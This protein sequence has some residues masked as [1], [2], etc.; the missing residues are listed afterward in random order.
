VH[1]TSL[2]VHNEVFRQFAKDFIEF[3]LDTLGIHRFDLRFLEYLSDTISFAKNINFELYGVDI[4]SSMLDDIYRELVFD[5]FIFTSGKS[6]FKLSSDN[7]I[8]SSDS[9]SYSSVSERAEVFN[10][11]IFEKYEGTSKKNLHMIAGKL[12]LDGISKDPVPKAEK[13]HLRIKIEDV[14]GR[15]DLGHPLFQNK[16][17]GKTN[18]IFDLI[19]LDKI[20]LQNINLELFQEDQFNVQVHSLKTEINNPILLSDGIASINL[21]TLELNA[22]GLIFSSASGIRIASGPLSILNNDLQINTLTFQTPGTAGENQLKLDK[23]SFSGLMLNALINKN[24]LVCNDVILGKVRLTGKILIPAATPQS[25]EQTAGTSPLKIPFDSIS[26]NKIDIP[27]IKLNNSLFYLSDEILINSDLA[28]KLEG[29]EL[30]APE[31]DIKDLARIKGYFRIGGTA[32]DIY[33]HTLNLE[34]LLFDFSNQRFALKELYVDYHPEI[35]AKADY[36]IH[37]LQLSIFEINNFNYEAL[38]GEKRLQFR[39]MN[40]SD[41]RLDMI[42]DKG[43]GVQ[44]DSTTPGFTPEDLLNF[45]YKELELTNINL[46]IESKS[47][48]SNPVIVINDFDL[49]HLRT[50]DPEHNFMNDIIFSF[51]YFTLTD[52]LRHQSFKINNGVY[53]NTNNTLTLSNISGGSIDILNIETLT[54][55]GWEFE[56]SSL[57]ASGMFARNTFPTRFAMNKLALSDANIVIS[58]EMQTNRNPSLKLDI[59]SFRRFGAL[60]T[61]LRVDTTVFSEVS[62]HYKTFNDTSSH[63]FLADSIGLVINNIDIDTAVFENSDPDI[64]RKMSVDF[65]GR[66][67]ISKDSLYEIR[68]G[69]ISYNFIENRVTIDSFQLIPRF[70][71]DEFFRRAVYQTDRV[72]LFGRRIELRD[73]HFEELFKEDLIHFGRIDVDSIYLDMTRDKKYL[74]KPNEFKPMPQEILRRMAQRF[75]IDTIM[76]FNSFVRYSEYVIKSDIPGSVFFDRFNLNIYN[77]SNDQPMPDPTS[78]LKINLNA[79]VM[80]QGRLEAEL[81]FPY[82]NNSTDYW[83]T[84]SS[85]TL[86]LTTLN[87]LTEN[88]LGI[89]IKRGE[90]HVENSF[91]TGDSIHSKGT[92]LFEYKKLKLGLYNRKKAQQNK[93]MFG[94]LTRFLINDILIH[95]NNP[96]FSRKP[97]IGQIYFERAPEKFIINY[98]WKSLLSG[99]LSTIGIN[100]K[101]QRHDRKEMKGK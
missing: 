36:Q 94:G 65:K 40:I 47:E 34:E 82:L 59:E 91:F 85:E 96:R 15:L 30:N 74:R 72:T 21:N 62:V 51:E 37:E 12:T 88:A 67:R 18:N 39:D 60:M 26:F 63:I 64:V 55:P 28:I 68:S 9:L 81:V 23:L 33:G 48:S 100:T 3:K 90:G 77:L 24:Q 79:Y 20:S 53:E 29:I 14:Q 87:P 54:R 1:K 17:Q 56:S 70:E 43:K 7:L 32:T 49:K 97:R 38:I 73:F 11:D 83:V 89:T 45:D 5:E 35:H 78:A 4:D 86:D 99:M 25:R 84:A 101:E 69:I 92:M 46:S 52:S 27:D 58:S 6:G 8:I 71:D 41:L 75:T 66:T 93:G 50:D 80:G 98:A 16:S 22:G 57:I 44:K 13:L 19:N 31:I 76:V 2:E 10:L 95:S 61:R 42:I